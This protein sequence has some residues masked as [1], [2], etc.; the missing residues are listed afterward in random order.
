MESQGVHAARRCRG[1][2]TMRAPTNQ[3]CSRSR[4]LSSVHPVELAY[5]CHLVSATS[6][7]HLQALPPVYKHGLVSG[8]ARP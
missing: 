1:G 8:V 7:S 6:V 2:V 5:Y 4:S 3:V